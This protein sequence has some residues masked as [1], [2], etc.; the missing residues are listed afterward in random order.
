MPLQ[1]V[2]ATADADGG[3]VCF[4][5]FSHVAALSLSLLRSAKWQA[6]FNKFKEQEDALNSKLIK[7]LLLRLLFC[8][9]FFF[10]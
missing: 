6:S 3:C 1:R 7:I 4:V 8:F 2:A 9:F 10:G 5:S